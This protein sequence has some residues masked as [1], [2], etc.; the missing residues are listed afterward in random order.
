MYDYHIHSN[1]SD[2]SDTPLNEMIEAAI[3]KGIVEIAVTDHYDPDNPDREFPMEIDFLGYHKQLAEAVE[4]FSDRIKVIKGIEIGV[5]HGDTLIKCENAAAAFPYDFI[6]GGFHSACGYDLRE[7]YFKNKNTEEGIYDFY[8]YIADCIRRF[9]NF[10]ILAHFN[11]I[12]RYA[13]YVPDYAPYME[14]IEHILKTLIDNNKGLEFNASC[15]RYNLSGRTTPA[16][17]ILGMYKSMGGEIM[18]IGSDAHKAQ[19]VGYGYHKIVDI[20]K[21]HGFNY[22]SLF[23][24]RKPSFVKI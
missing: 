9:K 11:I 7:N 6:I 4:H 20:L 3:E 16:S 10:D 22:I 14:I 19:D 12:D 23:E 13:D 17:E 2:D 24:K 1:F 21:S 15:F 18:T 5:Q 8:A